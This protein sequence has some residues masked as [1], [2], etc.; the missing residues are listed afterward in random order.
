MSYSYWDTGKSNQI[1][2]VI[3]VSF[4]TIIF[5]PGY[6][7]T[8]AETLKI[9]EGEFHIDQNVAGQIGQLILATEISEKSLKN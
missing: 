6:G 7:S 2:V 8:T 4:R 3:A 5:L 1:T 9:G